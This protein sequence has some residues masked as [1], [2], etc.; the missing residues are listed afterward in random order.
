MNTNKTKRLS[1]TA[2][3]GALSIVLIG[4]QLQGMTM[5]AEA[6]LPTRTHAAS[7]QQHPGSFSELIKRVRPAVVSVATTGNGS[8]P[9][10]MQQFQFNMP[11]LPEGSPFGEFF[12]HFFD[13]MP[14]SPEGDQRYETRGAGSGFIISDD[15]YIVTNHHVIDDADKIEVIMNDGTRFKA[16][17]KGIDSKTDLALLKI[18]SDETLPYVAF[19]DSDNADVG[20]WVVAVGNQ[21]GLGGSVTAGIISARGRDIQS[22]PFDDFLQI[23][24]PI[25]RGNSGGPL[26]TPREM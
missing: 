19:G 16:A 18:E 20:D 23:D 6:A 25:N 11:D 4:A 13:N 9:N 22:G 8:M 5:A 14:Q 12:Q 21:F 2:I 15:G 26:L 10:G 7:L 24:A 3:A 17:V 1:K